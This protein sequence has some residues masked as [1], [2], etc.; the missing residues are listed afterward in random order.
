MMVNTAVNIY[1]YYTFTYIYIHLPRDEQ[2]QMDLM[3]ALVV[4]VGGK[5]G[6]ITGRNRTERMA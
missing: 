3:G 6:G 4:V 1:I 2:R 5:V